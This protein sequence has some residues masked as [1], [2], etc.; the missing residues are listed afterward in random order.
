[1]RINCGD[2]TCSWIQSSEEMF[3]QLDNY[4]SAIVKFLE[5]VCTDKYPILSIAP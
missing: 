3:N 5:S 4:D 2:T 1:V